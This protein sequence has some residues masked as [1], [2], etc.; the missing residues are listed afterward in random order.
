MEHVG[1]LYN[2]RPLA[3]QAADLILN[4]IIENDL[5]AGAKL[6]NEFEL[7]RQIGVGRSTVREAIKILVSRNIVEIRRGAGTYVSEGQG[8]IEDP[9]GLT[10]VKDKKGLALDLL[11]VRLMMEPEIAMMAAEHAREEQIRGLYVQCEKVE[12]MIHEGKNHLE[13]DILFHKMIAA[14]SGNVV[15]EKLVPVI[16]S[17]IAVFVDVTNGRLKEETIE[18]H[19]EIVDAIAAKDGEGARCAMQMHLLYN[20]RAIKSILD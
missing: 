15:V 9:L 13:E 19:R 20:R 3:D 6:P 1:G 17:S 14:C 11:S 7:A 2:G 10:F 5:E 16:N 18:T 12:A 8:V 4:Y